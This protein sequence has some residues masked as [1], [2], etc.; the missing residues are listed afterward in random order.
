MGFITAFLFLINIGAW[1]FFN[2]VCWSLTGPTCGWLALAGI[3]SFLIAWAISGEAT[4]SLRDY[5]T[6]TDWELFVTKIKWS[7]LVSL[8][9]MFFVAAIFL[10][11][12]WCEL[13]EFVNWDT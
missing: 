2:V 13:R 1:I 8:I 6:Q 4:L 3:T 12:D 9:V 11:L 7:N 10:W 5:F